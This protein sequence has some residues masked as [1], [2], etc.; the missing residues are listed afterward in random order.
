MK[1]KKTVFAIVISLILMITTAFS[2]FA[3]SNIVKEKNAYQKAAEKGVSIAYADTE[4]NFKY[5]KF[6]SATQTT[7]SESNKTINESFSDSKTNIYNKMLNTIDYFNEIDLTLETS[8]L[9]D[10]KT[11]I[12]YKTNI[13]EGYAYETVLEDGILKSET[14]SNPNSEYL[15]FVDNVIKTYNQQYLG[16]FKR[17]DSP[18]IAL[19]KRIYD[20]DDG[21][22]CYVYRRN[23]TNCPLASYSLVPQEITFSYLKDFDN[24]EIEGEIEYSGRKCIIIDGKTSP[25]I[26]N[27][28]SSD[29]FMMYVDTETGILMKFEGLKNEKV[30]NYITVTDCV[31]GKSRTTIKQFDANQYSSYK[32]VFN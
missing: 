6:D 25:Y 9:G 2:A 31:F 21:I 23:I 16:S 27:K 20:E 24:W 32:E 12:S 29:E 4:K 11:I 30:T 13:D 26:S 3:I 14:Y 15:T 7:N 8:M 22:P 1:I 19:A 18:Y 10:K 17:S 5:T 28:H